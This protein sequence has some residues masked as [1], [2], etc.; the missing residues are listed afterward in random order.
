[1]DLGSNIRQLRN[2]MGM[3]LEDLAERT[4][5]S[6]AMLSDIERGAKNP[7]IKI[8]CQIAEVFGYT[9]SQLLGEDDPTGKTAIVTR[10]GDRQILVEPRTGVE[11]HLLAPPFVQRGLEIIWYV[12]PP[13]QFGSFPAHRTRTMEHITVVKGSLKYSLDEEEG[14]LDEGDSISFAADVSHDFYNP[15]TEPCCFFLV[16]DSTQVG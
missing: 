5:V 13:Q 4:G 12:I 9:V 8:V 6:R 16:I 2:Q 11:R 15:G 14:T 10:R 3:T 1:V 7:T